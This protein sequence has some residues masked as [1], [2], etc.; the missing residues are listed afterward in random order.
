[1]PDYASLYLPGAAPPSLDFLQRIA[2]LAQASAISPPNP[3]TSGGY[4]LEAPGWRLEMNVMPPEQLA[5]HLLGFNGYVAHLTGGGRT[6]AAQAVLERL[7]AVKLVLGCVVQPG[8]DPDGHARR[9]IAAVAGVGGGLLFAN[10]AVY[11]S[12]ASLLVGPP[13]APRR[14]LPPR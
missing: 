8:F 9:A 14:F 5:Q 3:G 12:D 6:P 1:M 13:R 10:D 4:R 2:P 11:D 7:A